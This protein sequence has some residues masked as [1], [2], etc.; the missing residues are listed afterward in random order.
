MF[1]CVQ[2]YIFKLDEDYKEI[3]S[4]KISQILGLRKTNPGYY[5]NGHNSFYEI[6]EL[7]LG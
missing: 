6:S 4:H 7:N 1:F 3:Y 5:F 2:G